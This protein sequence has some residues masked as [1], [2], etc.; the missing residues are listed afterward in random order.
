MNTSL[1]QQNFPD[2]SSDPAVFSSDSAGVKE[3]PGNPYY[4]EGVRVSYTAPAKW[5]NWL[6]NHISAWLRDSKTDKESIRAEML[7]VLS[8]ATITPSDSDEHQLSKGIDSVTYDTIEDY[9]N[10]EITE[11][12]D[13]V[14]VTH[15]VNQPYV[16]GY[17]LYIPETELL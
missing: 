7:N 16:V 4:G 13:G 9:D 14:M 17:T 10:E 5:W 11:E 1:A 12:I 15:K 3:K 2:P 6:W 8:D